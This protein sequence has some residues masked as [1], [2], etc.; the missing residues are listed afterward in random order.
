MDLMKQRKKSFDLDD[1][2]YYFESKEQDM[3]DRGGVISK[4][5]Q[6]MSLKEKLLA[7]PEQD[8]DTTIRNV[9]KML[10]TDTK[11]GK[12]DKRREIREKQAEA[13]ELFE[14]ATETNELLS[15]K[16]SDKVS[17]IK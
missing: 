14:K 15:I 4:N 7:L 8:F 5:A 11:D 16:N 2:K 13:L 17:A 12:K 3:I 10:T 9:E 1:L 6:I